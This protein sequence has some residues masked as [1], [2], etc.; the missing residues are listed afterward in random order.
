MRSSR[1]FANP[2]GRFRAHC[3]EEVRIQY[4]VLITISLIDDHRTHTFKSRARLTKCKSKYKTPETEQCPEQRI[5][6][7]LR[8]PFF[9]TPEFLLNLLPN[10]V[11]SNISRKR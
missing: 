10:E 5:H 2:D 6:A 9:H 4:G 8:V 3:R 7:S 1:Y 11:A